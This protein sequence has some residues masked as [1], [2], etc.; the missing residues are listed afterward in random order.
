M[1]TNLKLSFQDTST[2]E[3][4]FLG[5]GIGF[6]GPGHGFLLLDKEMVNGTG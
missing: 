6:H 1:I 3:T 5:F 4:A 2:F